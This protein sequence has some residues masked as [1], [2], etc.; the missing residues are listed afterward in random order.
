MEES[1][2]FAET[3]PGF[4]FEGWFAVVG[5]AGIASE[6]ATRLNR[7]IDAFLKDPQ[8]AKRLSGFGCIPNPGWTPQEANVFLEAER[9]R[10]RGIAQELGIKPQ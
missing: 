8:T 2:P 3:L 1:P 10:W 6:V 7:E 9:E 5:P 4:K